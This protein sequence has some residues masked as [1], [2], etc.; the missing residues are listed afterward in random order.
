MDTVDENYEGVMFDKML[1][2][3]GSYQFIVYLPKLRLNLRVNLHKEY[4]NF[5]KHMFKLYLFEDE[6]NL[7]RKIRLHLIE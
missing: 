6:E 5:E 7:R 4:P 2:N 3:D 1:R